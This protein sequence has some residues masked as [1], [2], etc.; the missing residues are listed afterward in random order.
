MCRGVESPL[1]PSRTVPDPMSHTTDMIVWCQTVA[2]AVT[3]RAREPA[4][5][6]ARPFSTAPTSYRRH[7][8]GGM[9]QNPTADSFLQ[10]ATAA[11]LGL[12]LRSSK[13][14][15]KVDMVMIDNVRVASALKVGSLVR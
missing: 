1:R 3:S 11:S 8:V 10:Q 12:P 13:A 15:P 7:S 5:C 4:S 6:K 9:V 14:S 2:K